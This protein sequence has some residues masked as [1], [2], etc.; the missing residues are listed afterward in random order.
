MSE[1]EK[2]LAEYKAEFGDDLEAELKNGRGSE[3][4]LDRIALGFIW[5]NPSRLVDDDKRLVKAVK[6]LTGQPRR[7]KMHDDEGLLQSM[8]EAHLL[9]KELHS[10]DK[11]FKPRSDRQLAVQ[12]AAIREPKQSGETAPE[13]LRKA[14]AKRKTELLKTV[15]DRAVA[16]E[17]LKRYALWE[18]EQTLT[19]FGIPFFSEN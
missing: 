12:F 5:A 4:L 9:D 18:L 7:A 14:F 15:D 13:R 17:V 2:A 8:A 3:D 11:R 19:K 6:A 1:F 10:R 16:V